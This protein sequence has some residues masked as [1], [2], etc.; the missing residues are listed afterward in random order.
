MALIDILYEDKYIV[1]L[2]KSARL[3]SVPYPGFSG[4]TAQDL[5]CQQ[6]RQRGMVRG[7]YRPQAVH[8]LDKDT[9]GVMMFALSVEAQ[10]RI[11]DSWQTMVTSRCYRALAE[12]PADKNRILPPAGTIDDPLAINQ[13]HH[14]YV[15][16]AKKQNPH[17]SRHSEKLISAVTHY[18]TVCVGS[19][20][21]LF[22]LELETGRTNQIRAHL[23]GKG[24]PL[25]G[26]RLF[27]S[28]TNPC[29]RLCLHA[30]SLEFVHP[31]TG[32]KLAFCVEE[33]KNWAGFC[34]R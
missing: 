27:K 11:M 15:P 4:K 28:K 5:L 25:A 6:R 34:S 9:S 16:D 8:R 3:L 26:D 30:R 19:R 31:Y 17:N 24:Y 29:N 23:A 12:N 14:S 32:E 33:P 1:V 20:Y 10:K 13:A 18:T 22:E 21:T 2:N 7:S